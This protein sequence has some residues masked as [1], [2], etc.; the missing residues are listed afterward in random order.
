MALIYHQTVIKTENFI[1]NYFVLHYKMYKNPS[2]EI[3][4]KRYKEIVFSIN[5][6]SH[7]LKPYLLGVLYANQQYHDALTDHKEMTLVDLEEIVSNPNFSQSKILD[8]ISNIQRNHTNLLAD[9]GLNEISYNFDFSSFID[10]YIDEVIYQ[11]KQLQ[12]QMSIQKLR[13]KFISEQS[14]QKDKKLTWKEIFSE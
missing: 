7:K 3:V 2:L 13:N 4:D 14:H 6:Y 8:M 11:N 10:G 9:T 12:E 1:N 5:N